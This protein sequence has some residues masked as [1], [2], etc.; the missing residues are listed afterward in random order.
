MDRVSREQRSKIM[1]SI[2]S[3]NT[4]PEVA[5]RRAL[6]AKRLRY[7]IH[8]G[9]EKIDIAFPSKRVAVFVDGCFWHSCPAHSHMPK[10]HKHYWAPKLKKNVERDRE[11]DNR[12]RTAG[13]KVIRFWEHDLENLDRILDKVIKLLAS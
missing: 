5:L 11:K 13:W 3:T 6:W 2:R 1:S 4:K 12:L 10:T 7:R 9:E 8:Y